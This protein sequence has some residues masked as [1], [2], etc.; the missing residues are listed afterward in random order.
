MAVSKRI[1]PGDHRAVESGDHRLGVSVYQ[2]IR[3]DID[4]FGPFRA[5]AIV[6]QDTPRMQAPSWTPPESAITVV[7]F[8]S[9]VKKSE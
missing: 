1:R 8:E 6:T 9:K 7:Q 2:N 3:A 4:G 5:I